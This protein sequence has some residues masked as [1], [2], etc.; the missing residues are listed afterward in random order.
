MVSNYYNIV[1][2]HG[3]FIDDYDEYRRGYYLYCSYLVWDESVL[4]VN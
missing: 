4:Y 1:A 3:I 2:L